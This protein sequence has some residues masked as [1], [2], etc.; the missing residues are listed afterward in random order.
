MIVTNGERG[1]LELDS[2]SLVRQRK[3]EAQE[4]ARVLGLEGVEFLGYPDSMLADYPINKLRREI[5]QV[6]RR[7]QPDTILTWDPFAAYEDHPDHRITGVAAA[8]AAA[9]TSMPLYYPEQVESPDCLRPILRKYYIAIHHNPP[10]QILD[11]TDQ[12]E[13]KLQALSCHRTQLR[14]TALGL[15]RALEAQ[16]A[17]IPAILSREEGWEKAVLE[18]VRAH[19]AELGRQIGTSYGEQFHLIVEDAAAQMLRESAGES[20]NK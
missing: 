19:D 8:E 15:V 14:S 17:E 18:A 4:A 16:N 1:T 12:M 9:F 5:M 11:I 6:Y 10:T 7:I 3:R 20:S 2:K 13:R